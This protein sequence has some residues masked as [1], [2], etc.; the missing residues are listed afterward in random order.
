MG[1]DNGERTPLLSGRPAGCC[2]G[3]GGP[4]CCGGASRATGNGANTLSPSSGGAAVPLKRSGNATGETVWPIERTSSR[5]SLRSNRSNRRLRVEDLL[6]N[7]EPLHSK[8]GASGGQCCEYCLVA[9]ATM[10]RV[11]HA[12]S[13]S[14]LASLCIC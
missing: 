7:E 13:H 9:C 11:S 10:R 12:H 2:G 5:S 1:K 6:E 8:C 4:G 14:P 3:K